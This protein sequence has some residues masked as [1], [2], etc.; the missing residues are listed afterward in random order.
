MNSVLRTA[1]KLRNLVLVLA[2]TLALLLLTCLSLS[3]SLSLR[4]LFSS[5]GSDVA[6]NVS[7]RQSRRRFVRCCP[8][9]EPNAVCG[10]APALP[11]V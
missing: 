3:L 5:S 8:S 10:R 9:Q 2:I 11:N 1:A 4:F 7:R 6:A